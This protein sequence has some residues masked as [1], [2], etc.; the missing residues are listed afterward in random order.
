MKSDA[1]SER[2]RGMEL[3][4]RALRITLSIV[5]NSC[6]Q[7]LRVRWFWFLKHNSKVRKL[8]VE[9]G[10]AAMTIL[11]H[12]RLSNH[13]YPRQSIA[14][15]VLTHPVAFSA[16]VT[17]RLSPLLGKTNDIM[18]ATLAHP[19][20]IYFFRF[21][22]RG[23]YTGWACRGHTRHDKLWEIL[24]CQSERTQHAQVIIKSPVG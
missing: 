13:W 9:S 5:S 12:D 11:S 7:S 18:C 2:P 8:P 20:S 21:T 24:F 3:Q 6:C 15:A 16:C 23:S 1:N 14:L 17:S 22:L 4:K 19:W 10:T